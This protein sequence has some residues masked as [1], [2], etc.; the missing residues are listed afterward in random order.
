MIVHSRET[1]QHITQYIPLTLQQ[2][3]PVATVS[4]SFFLG[5]VAVISGACAS[6]SV[7]VHNLHGGRCAL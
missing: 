2:F 7:Q 4:A 6:A 3:A 1:A 5:G